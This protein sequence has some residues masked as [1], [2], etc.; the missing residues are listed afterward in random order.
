MTKG[1][2][3][4]VNAAGQLGLFD[5][6]K[7]EQAERI[8]AQP[9]RLSISSRFMA[10]IRQAMKKAA[11]SRDAIADEMTHLAGQTVT[12]NML[13]SW[14]A[15]SHPHR[16]PAELLPAFCAAVDNTDPIRILAETVGIYTL[17]GVDALRAEV[18][19]IREEEQKLAAERKRRELFLK[20]LG[21]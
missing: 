16:M 7:Q 8:A 1:R 14:T 17:P 21:Q 19:R 15:E 13:N 11:K 6:L 18:Q 9:G 3:R 4:I 10:T 5:L 20:E 2:K 12:V